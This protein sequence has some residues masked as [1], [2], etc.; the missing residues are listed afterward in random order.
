MLLVFHAW[1][2]THRTDKRCRIFF[3]NL[4]KYLVNLMKCVIINNL[5]IFCIQKKER[6]RERE[7]KSNL[8]W[9]IFF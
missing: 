8:L 4:I 6:E 1:S 2:D 5:S 7:K 9:A 3:L